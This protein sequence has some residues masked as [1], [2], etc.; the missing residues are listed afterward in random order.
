MAHFQVKI[1]PELNTTDMNER[2]ERAGPVSA[3]GDP[4]NP[5]TLRAVFR[6][7]GVTDSW[8]VNPAP[9]GGAPPITCD[10]GASYV[11][12]FGD[13]KWRRASFGGRDGTPWCRCDFEGVRAPSGEIA[14][15]MLQI[16][17]K[18]DQAM[19]LWDELRAAEAELGALYERRRTLNE[20]ARK[21]AG[22]GASAGTEAPAG[23]GG[24]DQGRP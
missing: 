6:A 10:G 15:V 21:Q 3:Y 14:H 1:P 20:Q 5:E 23:G 4:N 16:L 19:R 18:S 17:A 12:R 8:P 13:G 22:A 2:G 24:D 11:L 9:D 7:W